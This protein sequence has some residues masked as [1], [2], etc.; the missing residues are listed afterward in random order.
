MTSDPSGIR[1]G[2]FSFTLSWSNSLFPE[3][4]R[5]VK[6]SRCLPSTPSWCYSAFVLR[7]HQA[8]LSLFLLNNSVCIFQIH[9]AAVTQYF[10]NTPSWS[11]SVCIFPLVWEIELWTLV[12]SQI[13]T[14]SFVQSVFNLNFSADKCKDKTFLTVWRKYL[15]NLIC[16]YLLR[17]DR[18]CIHLSVLL[19]F[20]NILYATYSRDLLYYLYTIDLH[21]GD[22]AH[23]YSTLPFLFDVCVTMHHWYNKISNQLDATMTV[24]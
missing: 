8:A 21:Y 6:L 24:Y 18:S 2:H 19:S 3:Y 12:D 10:P 23:E 20:H 15:T 5:L 4:T 14:C 9:H 11:N 1:T 17:R 13:K 7:I 16:P 22:M